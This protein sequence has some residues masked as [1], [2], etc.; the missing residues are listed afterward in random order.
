LGLSLFLVIESLAYR[1]P[2]IE[3]VLL[4][5]HLGDEV[6]AIEVRWTHDLSVRDLRPS[7]ED[8]LERIRLHLDEALDRF[9]TH[10][11]EGDCG[12]D[13]VEDE[14]VVCWPCVVSTGASRRER[15]GEISIVEP[16][17]RS[18]C[19]RGASVFGGDSSDLVRSR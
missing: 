15:S 17:P 16:M 12:V 10:H 18:L 1:D 3:V 19:A 5:P 9:L 8:E 14:E 4:Q 2:A 13:L 11:P 6:R 7:R